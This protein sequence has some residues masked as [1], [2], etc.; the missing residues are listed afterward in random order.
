MNPANIT[1]LRNLA[2]VLHERATLERRLRGASRPVAR[3]AARSPYSERTAAELATLP[4]SKFLEHKQTFSY[5]IHTK[6]KDPEL[7]ERGHGPD[8]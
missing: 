4:E 1:W 7:S 3:A 2:T 8:L 5:N 6:K